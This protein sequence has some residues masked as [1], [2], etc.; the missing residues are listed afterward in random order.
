[1]LKFVYETCTMAV[2]LRHTLDFGNANKTCEIRTNKFCIVCLHIFTAVRAPFSKLKCELGPCPSVEFLYAEYN[3][4]T[5]NIY[6]VYIY[7][8]NI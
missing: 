4:Y 8:L 6:S 1:M 5:P 2:S 3:I 7:I